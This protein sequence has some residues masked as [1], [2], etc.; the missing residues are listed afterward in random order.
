[1]PSTRITRTFY[2]QS[3]IIDVPYNLH[4]YTTCTFT[5]V[6][7]YLKFISL[8]FQNYRTKV[9]FYSSLHFCCSASSDQW[10]YGAAFASF[11]ATVALTFVT[12]VPVTPLLLMPDV[13]DVMRRLTSTQHRKHFT[14]PRRKRLQMGYRNVD[15]YTYTTC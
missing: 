8:S 4:P 9:S 12:R 1:M 15:L 11:A 10:V 7:S 3:D 14:K 5:V 6:L 2:P 13:D